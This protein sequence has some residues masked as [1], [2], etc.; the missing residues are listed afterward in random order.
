LQLKRTETGRTNVG[1]AIQL[2]NLPNVDVQ[3]L[4]SLFVNFYK[5]QPLGKWQATGFGDT[6]LGMMAQIMKIPWSRFINKYGSR[7]SDRPNR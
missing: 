4:Q 5:Y 2:E 3:L 1:G 7:R 6:E